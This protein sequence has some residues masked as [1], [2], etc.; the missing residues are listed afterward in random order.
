MP[1]PESTPTTDEVSPR[2]RIERLETELARERE[3]SRR[4]ETFLMRGGVAVTWLD[5]DGVVTMVNETGARNLGGAPGD[6][7]GRSMYDIVPARAKQTRE[8]VARAFAGEV[9]EYESRV[10]LP[11]GPMW[12]TSFYYPVHDASGQVVA[13]QIVAQD[14]TKLRLAEQA[15]AKT[16]RALDRAQARAQVGSYDFDLETGK[17]TWSRQMSILF[18][19]DPDT[20]PP[21]FEDYLERYHPDDQAR[22]TE[23]YRRAQMGEYEGVY[24]IRTN[25]AFGP[26]RYLSGTVEIERTP[27]GRPRRITGTVMD[28]TGHHAVAEERR[29]LQS[30]FEHAQKL[31]SLGVLAGGIAHD[32]NNLLVSV[33]GNAELTLLDLGDD[34]RAREHLQE[35]LAASHRAAELCSQML[36]YSGRGQF[37]VRPVDLSA[38]VRDMAHLLEVSVAKRAVIKSELAAGLPAIRADVT[39]VGQ[40]VMNLIT[41]AAEALNEGVHE[42]RVRTGVR[43]CTEAELSASY[44]DDAL[45]EGEY[46][47]LEVAD[48]GCGMDEEQR[49][50]MFDPFF[51]SKATGRGLGLAAVLGII[52]GHGGAIDVASAPGEGT[53]ITVCFPASA[54]EPEDLPD[55]GEWEAPTPGAGSIMVVDDEAPVRTLAE[56]ALERNGYLVFTASDGQEAVEFF[57]EY[58]GK[59]DLVVLDVTMPRMDGRETLIRLREIDPEVRVILMSGYDEQSA[60]PGLVRDRKSDF[61]QKPFRPTMLIER[62]QKMLDRARGE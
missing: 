58:H 20:D 49:S 28:V 1:P 45:P 19:L 22:V 51:S 62:V 34:A 44:V 39:Q 60:V 61:L 47:F 24:E 33:M 17:R 59:I 26:M 18:G 12:F 10:E 46:V 8:R 37:V 30:Q 42:I 9:H 2:A 25:P 36:A 11:G 38:I 5:A 15:L 4:F 41:N 7:V 55:S 13:A 27:D 31:E 54:D 6:F 16:Q 40:I 43:H 23:I 3:R 35:I 29:E 50:R 57:R 21:A 14:L 53:R 48:D 52:R 32:F 56:R